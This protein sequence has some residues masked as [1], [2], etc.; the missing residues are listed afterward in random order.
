M[1]IEVNIRE[2]AKARQR[3]V[4]TLSGGGSLYGGYDAL[5]YKLISVNGRTGKLGKYP[6]LCKL[7]DKFIRFLYEFHDFR[8]QRLHLPPLPHD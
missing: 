3:L 2:R 5:D 6:I 7:P 4:H 1:G 8:F